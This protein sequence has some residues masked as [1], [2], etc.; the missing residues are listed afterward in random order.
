MADAPARLPAIHQ[1]GFFRPEV[2]P[3]KAPLLA[4]ARHITHLPHAP[5]AQQRPRRDPPKPMRSTGCKWATP[6]DPRRKDQNGAEDRPARKPDGRDLSSFVT[7]LTAIVPNA[8]KPA[9]SKPGI[10]GVNPTSVTPA[11][12]VRASISPGAHAANG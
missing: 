8:M 4:P 10:I 7:T 2:S 11:A 1:P 9:P 6:P 12:P 5:A 3:R